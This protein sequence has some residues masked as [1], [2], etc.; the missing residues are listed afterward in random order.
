[1]TKRL[2]TAACAAVALAVTAQAAPSSAAAHRP[3]ARAAAG[4]LGAE[5]LA[6]WENLGE[7]VW[8]EA[9]EEHCMLAGG[10]SC[11]MSGKDVDSVLPGIERLT[12]ELGDNV[13]SKPDL[14]RGVHRAGSGIRNTPRDLSRIAADI[15][16]SSSDPNVRRLAETTL[17]S[18]SGTK[19]GGRKVID[20]IGD[21]AEK[22]GEL[23]TGHDVLSQQGAAAVMSAV[24]GALPVLGDAWSI[25]NAVNDRDVESGVTALISVAGAMVA[26]VCAPAGVVIAVGLVVYTVAKKMWGWLCAKDRDWRLDPPGDPRDLVEKGADFTWETHLGR[27]RTGPD[28]GKDVAYALQM[29][30]FK[31]SG[32]DY[33][34]A[35][36]KLMLNSRWTKGAERNTDP[37]TYV[38]TGIDLLGLTQ[39]Y[40]STSEDLQGTLRIAQDGKIVHKRC[41]VEPTPNITGDTLH[42]DLAASEQVTISADKPALVT[43]DIPYNIFNGNIKDPAPGSENPKDKWFCDL[44]DGPCV[45][46]D[47]GKYRSVLKLEDRK[48]RSTYLAKIPFGYGLVPD[49]P[50]AE[51]RD[52]G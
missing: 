45:P 40:T 7:D 1:M 30:N 52:I 24:A 38:L 49:L 17:P 50:G 51:L 25:A 11:E 42:C 14:V 10:P 22:V 35:H 9:L 43:L 3:P 32:A 37:V 8:Q 26:T 27:R 48:A 31:D 6:L 28:A 29:T 39:V 5:Q 18:P 19:A 20:A 2:L 46:E 23:N 15:A 13:T 44:A 33:F 36:P 47:S 4:N 21:F 34:W 16:L 41:Y 12:K